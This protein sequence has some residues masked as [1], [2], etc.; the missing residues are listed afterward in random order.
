MSDA[1]FRNAETGTIADCIYV[2][3]PRLK[4]IRS[5]DEIDTVENAFFIYPI[6]R[7]QLR[8]EEDQKVLDEVLGNGVKF[9]FSFKRKNVRFIQFIENKSEIILFESNGQLSLKVKDFKGNEIP[10]NGTYQDQRAF[11][12][13]E[14]PEDSI[15]NKCVCYTIT[16][17]ELLSHA[18]EM[19]QA[20]LDY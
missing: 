1:K 5:D 3:A 10:T 13:V 2:P 19:K 11:Y 18:E 4:F 7:F 15:G 12:P 8:N 6:L 9:N 20:F 14:A 16:Y 17:E